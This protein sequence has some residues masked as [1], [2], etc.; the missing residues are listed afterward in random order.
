MDWS[1]TL[2]SNQWLRGSSHKRLMEDQPASLQEAKRHRS[3]QGFLNSARIQHPLATWKAP[4]HR[5]QDM[6]HM[7][8]VMSWPSSFGY[9]IL[10]T[11]TSRFCSKTCTWHPS[12]GHWQRS[13]QKHQP[14]RLGQKR[15]RS[16]Q[17]DSFP[18]PGSRTM[19]HIPPTDGKRTSAARKNSEVFGGGKGVLKMNLEQKKQITADSCTLPWFRLDASTPNANE[20]T[21]EKLLCGNGSPNL[22]QARWQYDIVLN[23]CKGTAWQTENPPASDTT[24]SAFAG[25]MARRSPALLTVDAK[26]AQ[27]HFAMVQ[28]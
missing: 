1:L 8:L 27:S 13:C 24:S 28:K 23:L 7:C 19:H 16:A 14:S 26:L 3:A 12:K 21:K 4:T 11:Q 22:N 10:L 18:V 9:P 15:N 6:C 5:S 25:A 20:S 17:Q 2:W